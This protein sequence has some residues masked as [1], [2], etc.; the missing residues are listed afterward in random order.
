MAMIRY[1]HHMNDLIKS[2]RLGNYNSE[3]IIDGTAVTD[4]LV[5]DICPNVDKYEKKYY[6]KYVLE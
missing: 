5:T 4:H 2:M 1:Q 3:S 6:K